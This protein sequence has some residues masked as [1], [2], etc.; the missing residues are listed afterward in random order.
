MGTLGQDFR[1]GWRM[2]RKQP[3]FTAVAVIT[4]ALAIGANTAIFSVVYP[5][6]LRP[7]PFGNPDQLVT[8]GESRDKIGCC[9][10]SASYPD[11]LDWKNSAKSFQSIAGYGG[12]AYTITGNGDPKTVFA[13]MVTT[14]FFS[15]LGVTPMLGRDFLP[16]ED[17]PSGQGPTV[18]LLTYSFWR[19][20]FG[21]D[22]SIVGRQVRL[23][24]KP[25]TIVG[26]LPRD[27][28]LTPAGILPIWVPLHL[29][30]YELT[31]RDCA[32]VQRDCAAG[33]G[34]DAGAGELGDEHHRRAAGP[35]I[36]ASRCRHSRV[37]GAAAP[38]GCRRHSAAVAGAVW[39]GGFR[40]AGRLCQPRYPDV[41]PIRRPPPRIRGTLRARRQ[42]VAP[43]SAVAYRKLPAVAN[44][45]GHWFSGRA[46]RR[47]AI[48]RGPS[49]M[50]SSASCLI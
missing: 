31:A 34:S 23:D 14:N 20:D 36:S 42:P 44:G 1:Y 39:R 38:A 13:A 16:G 43:C 12:D 37:G 22:R 10:Y 35:A 2:L 29:N 8:V 11:Y 21:G 27:F 41:Q 26:I 18:A 15:T 9:S 32:L 28:E 6:L 50:R 48:R 19:S 5:V 3:G 17:L 4:L 45:R 47:L 33:S 24:G 7:L 30:H 46:D 25:V 49:P 40:V